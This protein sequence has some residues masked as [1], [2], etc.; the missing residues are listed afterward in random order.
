MIVRIFLVALSTLASFALIWQLL[1]GSHFAAQASPP[2]I[3]ETATPSSIP[4]GVSFD[5]NGNVWVAEPGCDPA[6]TCNAQLQPAIAE[7]NRQNFTLAQNYTEPAGFSAPLFLA[8]DSSGNIWF[9]EPAT[10]AIG[11][12][13]VNNGNATWNQFIVPTSNATPYGLTFDLAGNL[14]F[15]EL[16]ASSI[17]EFNPATAQFAETPTPAPNSNPYGIV[18]PDPSTGS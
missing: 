11:E 14:W 16:T 18:G 12:L 10:N 1:A 7:Y 8:V 3:R 2:T 4:W 6:P 17:G 15:T 13:T 5:A 9:T